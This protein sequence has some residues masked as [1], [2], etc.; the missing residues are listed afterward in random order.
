MIFRPEIK[1]FTKNTLILTLFFTLTL[2]LSWG[3]IAPYLGVGASA[4]NDA[5]FLQAN[6][7][8]LGNSATAISLSIGQK[9]KERTKIGGTN[10][11]ASTISVAELLSHP[12]DAEDRLISGHMQAITTYANILSTDIAKMLDAAD[13][14]QVALDEHIST[15]KYYGNTT[16]DRLK[17]LAEQIADLKGSATTALDEST[18]AKTTLQNSLSSM[19]PTWVEDA[20]KKYTEGKNREN[21][22]RIYIV[23]LEKFVEMYTKLQ[24]KNKKILETITTNRDALIKRS[25]IVIPS[26]GT[27][28]LRELWVIQTAGEKKSDN[29]LE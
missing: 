8:Y 26:S 17:I 29:T 11:S 16:N 3:Y 19:N 22:S 15:L 1:E 18:R 12:E 10:L 9:E 4:S 28:I 14:R 21:Q 25:T 7:L 2:H 27:E 20:M 24:S 6:T 23:Y 13:D 5:R